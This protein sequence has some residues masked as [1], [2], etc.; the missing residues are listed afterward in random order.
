MNQVRVLAKDE[1]VRQAPL[2]L[3]VADEIADGF[4]RLAAGEVRQPPVT[5]LE[6]PEA[7]GELDVK[8][9][10]VPGWDSFC[11]KLSTGFF[12]NPELGLPS[13]SGLM[14]VLSAETGRPLAVLLD[15]GY[16]TELR[17]AAAGAVAADALARP[18]ARHVAILGAGA[19]ARWQLDALRLVRNVT[20][21]D[22]WARRPAAAKAFA[23]AARK[24]T[25]LIVTPSTSVA[26]AVADADVVVTATPAREPLLYADMLPPGVHVTAMGADAAGKRELAADV[27]RAAD[28]LV[29]DALAQSRTL[30][31][32]QHADDATAARAI[33]LGDV[34]AGEAPGRR[35]DADVT[36]CD[37]TGTGVQDTV[38]A[39]WV[40]ARLEG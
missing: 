28:V 40:L 17:T 23:R 8:T 26:D 20:H 35:T 34:L 4:E 10:Y 38:V 37:L 3:E 22:V 18:D 12:R 21:V 29:V 32:L 33:L 31:E 24:E 25:G 36:V 15:D 13:A 5:S 11:V 6:I 27:L 9:A 2:T 39:R 30:G 16:L 19:Q 1:L 14:V 7:E